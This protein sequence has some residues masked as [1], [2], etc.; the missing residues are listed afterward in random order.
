V[1]NSAAPDTSAKTT[2]RLLQRATTASVVVACTLIAV[3]LG[4]WIATDSVS[5]LASLL[6]SLLDAIASII[7]L[8][9]VRYAL[10]PADRDHRFGH[11]KA[12]PLAALLQACLILGSCA[13]ILYEATLRLLAPRPPETLAPALV[14]MGFS[15]LVTLVLIAFQTYVVRR[16]DSVAIRAD[17]VHYRADLLTNSATLAALFLTGHGL[18]LADPLFGLAIGLWLLFTTRAVLR[19]ALDQLLDR[20][21]PD[22][23]RAAILEITHGLVGADGRCFLRTRRA[24]RT[25]HV[26]VHLT[27]SGDLTLRQAAAIANAVKGG[28]LARFPEADVLVDTRPADPDAP[29]PHVAP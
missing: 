23:E 26:Q 12:E 21:L 27:L 13:F 11:G 28:I 25:R 10:A 3:K 17:S 20:E 1:V 29:L 9:A 22:G 5:L 8:I 19:G 18:P 15:I 14:V 7:S 4:A 24:G 2:Q 6:D 16:T